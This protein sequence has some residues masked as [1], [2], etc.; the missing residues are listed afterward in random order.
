MTLASHAGTPELCIHTKIQ[1]IEA[2]AQ[3]LLALE[4]GLSRPLLAM[5]RAHGCGRR[6]A[7]LV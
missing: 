3:T 6:I 4:R 5:R 1:Q 2:L 7:V